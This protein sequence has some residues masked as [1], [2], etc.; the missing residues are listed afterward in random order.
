MLTL[1][2]AAARLQ[3]HKK[4]VLSVELHPGNEVAMTASADKMVCVWDANSGKKHHT[5]SVHGDE[6]TGVSLH[7][8]G[9]YFVAASKDK[10]WSFSTIETGQTLATNLD[11]TLQSGFSCCQFHP[12]GGI[13]GAGT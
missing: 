10:S 7:P 8:C 2:P 1:A 3:G 4:K 5:I 9:D 6:V 11:Q 12:D 13:F